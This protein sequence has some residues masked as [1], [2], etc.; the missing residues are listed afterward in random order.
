ME[1]NFSEFNNHLGTISHSE[2][3]LIFRMLDQKISKV[4]NSVI[5]VLFIR[6]DE[7]KVQR[8]E[9]ITQLKSIIV[10]LFLVQENFLA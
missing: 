8:F 6:F 9:T 3:V 2:L 5:K 4:K 1:Q 7:I 10:L